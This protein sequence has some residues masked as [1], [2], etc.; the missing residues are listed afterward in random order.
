MAFALQGPN[1]FGVAYTFLATSLLEKLKLRNTMLVFAG[2]TFGLAGPAIFLLHER[3]AP[4]EPAPYTTADPTEH[5]QG[6]N[7]T[8]LAPKSPNKV[9]VVEVPFSPSLQ[10][11]NTWSEAVPPKRYYQRSIF[12]IFNIANVLQACAYYLPFIY[13]PSFATQLG[14]NKNMSA[15]IL[16]VAN[17]G[18]VFG[19]IGFGQL[20]DKIH[21]NW[22]IITTMSV[23]SSSTFILWGHFG[24]GDHNLGVLIAY[25]FLF[26][27]F[28]AGFLALWARM[29]TL[30]GEKDAQMVY[31]TLCAGRGVGS[32]LSGPVSQ[33]LLAQPSASEF[34]GHYGGVIVFVGSC[35]AASGLMG[36]GAVLALWWKKEDIGV[37]LRWREQR[38]K[39]CPPSK[40]VHRTK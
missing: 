13:L 9:T 18:Q 21:V 11:R 8:N 27:S 6:S 38:N 14:Y 34:W 3:I 7:N 36:A 33:I 10:Q 1:L 15:L 12:Y 4:S 24:T 23:T 35:M 39:P 32:I 26:G 29:G 20:S 37:C 28:G 16:A 30:F 2:L 17:L 40:F 19:D 22:L 25:A 31:S 5:R